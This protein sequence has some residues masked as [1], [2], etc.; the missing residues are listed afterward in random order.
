VKI[1]AQDLQAAAAAGIVT[2]E[3][4]ERL[5]AFLRERTHDRLGDQPGFHATHILYYLGGLIAIGAMSLFMTLGWQRYGGWGL[6]GIS[7]AYALLG[8]GLT[9]YLLKRALRIPAGIMAA[10]TI[11]LTPLAVYALQI[12]LGVWP[13]ATPYRDYHVYVKWHWIIMELATLAVGAILFQRYRIPF[14]LMPVAVTLWYLS[15]DLA[16]FLFP[17][18]DW[19][20]YWD[21]R[22]WVSL[23]FGLAVVLLAFW[24]DLRSRHSRD[25]YAF[26][27]YLFGVLAFWGGLSLMRS[28]SELNKFL[29]F[30]INL[31]LI[32]IG[33]TLSRRIFA[34]CGGLG[35]AGYL[36]YLA[37]DLFKDSLLFPFVLTFIGLAVIGL[38]IKWQKYE[39]RIQQR[40]LEWLPREVGELVVRRQGD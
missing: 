19:M 1:E 39:G 36:G 4:G 7:I 18:L 34:I 10:F 13:D 5:W 9:E 8:L 20:A 37:H 16:P 2:P 30:C 11:A 33:A 38:G 15:M 17:D 14:L 29:Y 22:K 26:W 32:A 21:V 6:F 24:V 40:M 28:D 35:V 3:Q 27:L 23:W 12:A 25:D 31:G